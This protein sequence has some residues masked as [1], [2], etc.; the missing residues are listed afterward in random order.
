MDWMGNTTGMTSFVCNHASV[1]WVLSIP[2]SLSTLYRCSLTTMAQNK[3]FFEI[4]LLRDCCNHKGSCTLVHILPSQLGSAPRVSTRQLAVSSLFKGILAHSVFLRASVL[5]G[6]ELATS[7]TESERRINW[8]NLTNNAR[9]LL[10]RTLSIRVDSAW[11][12][13][14]C[15][16]TVAIFAHGLRLI[17]IKVTA[18]SQNAP[19]S[20]KTPMCFRLRVGHQWNRADI[21]L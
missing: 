19:Q 18:W 9:M 15:K 3:T 1:K 11:L 12:L 13:H 8:A 4:P 5:A 17:E 10:S 14:A 20:M 16:D 7:H 6:L 2:R 21:P